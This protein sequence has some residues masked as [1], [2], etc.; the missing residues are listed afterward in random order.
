MV[1]AKIKIEGHLLVIEIVLLTFFICA[2]D[3]PQMR[4]QATF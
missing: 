4:S 3:E 2:N 1:I